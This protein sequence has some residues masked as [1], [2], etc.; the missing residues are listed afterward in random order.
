MTCAART[1]A[2][3]SSP[4]TATPG[5]SKLTV[6]TS[7]SITLFRVTSAPHQPEKVKS[8]TA[9]LYAEGLGISAIRLVLKTKLG[10][11]YP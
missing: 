7:A 2:P 5:A 3:T 6:A 4:S 9:E 10:T 1:A 8:L 11:V